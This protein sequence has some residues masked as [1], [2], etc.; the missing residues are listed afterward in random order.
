MST[1]QYDYLETN[2]VRLHY[3]H[4]GRGQLML[5]LHGFPEFWY[6]WRHQLAAFANDY[7]VVA[8]DMRGYNLS[9]KP[10]GKAAYELPILLED[11]KGMIHALGYQDCILVA[12]D[13]G[14]AIAWS[15]AYDHPKMVKRLIV[16]NLPHPAKLRAGLRTPRQLLRSWYMFAFQLPVLPE[17]LLRRR[18]YQ[19]IANALEGML[20]RKEALSQAD[21][22]AFRAAAAQ[23]GALTAMIHYYRANLRQFIKSDRIHE[24]EPL[25]VPTLL[26]W[27]EEDAALGKEL[28]YGTE[29][30]VEDLTL[31][32]IPQCSHWVQQ[33]QPDLVN[34]YM[35]DFLATLK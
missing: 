6:S 20:I 13:W 14:G 15:F 19:G 32:Y 30:Y 7:H 27:G 1:L 16:M 5:F 17:W 25:T 8:V 33:E 35:R 22:A 10:E 23:P 11:V 18:N 4:Q 21:L 3:A 9:D 24:E 34:Q 26:I 29:E 31:C 28:T 2:G 12:H